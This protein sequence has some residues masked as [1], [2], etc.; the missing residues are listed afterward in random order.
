MAEMVTLPGP[1]A[2][3]SSSLLLLI[4]ARSVLPTKLTATVAAMPKLCVP[5]PAA[6]AIATSTA[7]LFTVT[8]TLPVRSSSATLLISAVSGLAISV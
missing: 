4:S 7:V 3:L 6:P 1:L 5:M 8:E 2:L